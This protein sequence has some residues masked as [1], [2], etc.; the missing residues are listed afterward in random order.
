M[1]DTNNSAVPPSPSLSWRAGL[2]ISQQFD[3]PYFSIDNGLA[4][5]RYVF[6]RHNGIPERWQHWPWAQAPCFN[7]IETGFG[8]GLNFLATW[9]QW[10]ES[11]K[12]LPKNTGWLHFT[13]IEKYPLDK[14][15]LQQALA[16]WPELAS[17]TQQLLDKYPLALAGPQH[18]TWPAEKIS[19]TLWF[20]DVKDALQEISAPVH[21]WYLDGFAPAKNPEMWNDCLY[22]GMRRISQNSDFFS[23][24]VQPTLATFTAAG[25]VR[26]GFKGAGFSLQKSKGFGRKREM[27][28]GQFNFSQ[29]PEQPSYYWQKPWLQRQSVSAQE[30]AIIGAG[31]AGCFTARALAERGYQVS[32]FDPKGI[33]NEA[34]GNAQGGVYIKLSAGDSAEHSDFY[35]AAFQYAIQSFKQYLGTGDKSNS[36]WQQCGLLQLAF[37]N[38]EQ[39]RQERFFQN[40]N[41]PKEFIRAVSQAEASELAGVELSSG[42]L[43]LQQAGWASPRD[44]CQKLLEHPNIQLVQEKINQLDYSKQHWQLRNEHGST[45]FPQVVLANAMQAGQLLQD[46]YLPIKNI[47]GQL[48]YLNTQYAP[49]L[50]TVLSGT[51]YLAPA[52]NQ[53]LCLG[54]TFDLHSTNPELNDSDHLKNLANLPALG[55]AWQSLHKQGLDAIVGGRVGFRCSSPDYLPM[56]GT[57][58]ATTEF[59][60]DFKQMI[61]NSKDIPTVPYPNLPGLW[62]NIAHGAKGLVSAPMTAELLACQISNSALPISQKLTEALWPGR[63]LL[64]DMIRR[65]IETS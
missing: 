8:T 65:K 52:L 63:F 33:A 24:T 54:A 51:C 39:Q 57:V 62:L 4:E 29:G 17:L 13:S 25:T 55:N 22:Q 37:D 18:L 48:S 5:T 14:E 10:R 20:A 47:R 35:L 45:T 23:S 60:N 3:D 64:R 34:S 7:I 36:L 1:S 32:I 15:Q 41:F 59:I 9:Q 53:Q 43:F 58:P 16:L 46:A 49:A 40:H 56:V 27:L 19:L 28:H 21:A 11:R 38:K 61:K 50:N 44:L 2:P 30:I 26:R 31:L 12:N 6:L 42:G